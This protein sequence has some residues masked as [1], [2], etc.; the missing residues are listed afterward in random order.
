LKAGDIM[1]LAVAALNS[2]ITILNVNEDQPRLF[3]FNWTAHLESPE[4]RTFR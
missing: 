2:N 1:Q 3:A 4:L